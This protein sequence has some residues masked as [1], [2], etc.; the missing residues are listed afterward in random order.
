MATMPNRKI[1]YTSAVE[2]AGIPDICDTCG[3]RIDQRS[4][5]S[6]AHHNSPKHLPYAGKRNPWKPR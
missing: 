4:A 2:A 5:A 1:T 3:Q 6:I